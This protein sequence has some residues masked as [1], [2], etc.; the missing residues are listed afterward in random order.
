MEVVELAGK[1]FVTVMSGRRELGPVIRYSPSDGRLEKKLLTGRCVARQRR[2]FASPECVTGVMTLRNRVLGIGSERLTE[3]VSSRALVGRRSTGRAEAKT[4]ESR[5]MRDTS[6]VFTWPLP[7]TCVLECSSRSSLLFAHAVFC[8]MPT[9]SWALA[10]TILHC[11]S[12]V[13]DSC[14]PDLSGPSFHSK[15]PTLIG[16]FLAAA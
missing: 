10:A 14:S 16:R 1:P 5:V 2:A 4:R 3:F 13:T 7:V 6:G 15:R 9:A 11:S 8:N 12:Y